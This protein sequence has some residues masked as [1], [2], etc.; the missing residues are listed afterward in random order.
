MLG[1]KEVSFYYH[2]DRIILQDISFELTAGDILCL[3]GPNGTGKTTLLR[4]ILSLQAIKSGCIE[5][6]G[7]DLSKTTIKK[8]AEMMAYVPQATLMAFPYE[9]REVVLMGR[10]AHLST[11]GRPTAK[12][13]KLA[14]E[15]MD[16]L[17]ILHMGKYLFNEMSGG[18]KQ[19]VLVARALAQQSRILVM[20]EP[21]ANLDYKNQ[22]QML[23]TI[24]A[25]AQQD[26]AIL[27]TS[28]FPDHAFWACN[29]VILMRDGSVMAQGSPDEVVTTEH[30]SR[31]YATPVCVAKAVLPQ[32]DEVTKVCIPIMN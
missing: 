32:R 20:D 11:G 30:L 1:V 18:E 26:Y 27:M 13:R 4:C 23:Q 6:G 14:D 2:P 17:G 3:L 7:V 25:L 8:R 24:K 21:T 15:A 28:H 5:I 29:R 12:D 16:K 10:V 19:M 31:L 22:I 9:A